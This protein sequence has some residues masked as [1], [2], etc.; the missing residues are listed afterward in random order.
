MSEKYRIAGSLIA[1]KR[2][3]VQ[4]IP[5]LTHCQLYAI[6]SLTP[7]AFLSLFLLFPLFFFR[8]PV[9][10]LSCL[11]V[12]YVPLSIAV[13][14]KQF[15][16]FS[17][18]LSQTFSLL[19]FLILYLPLDSRSRSPYLRSFSLSERAICPPAFSSSAF[20]PPLYTSTQRD[21]LIRC[22]PPS[23]HPFSNSLLLRCF[24][25]ADYSCASSLL[26]SL[27][28][29]LYQVPSSA[30]Q[31]LLIIIARQTNNVQVKIAGNVGNANWKFW[32]GNGIDISKDGKYRNE[33]RMFFICNAN[34]CSTVEESSEQE[35][36]C[37][38][39]L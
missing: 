3:F 12:H 8:S 27:S 23:L 4:P 21:S 14:K 11:I 19:L 38:P 24:R 9:L 6:L 13:S 22:S 17:F 25:S 18:F 33:R 7:S 16:L 20:I 5:R 31:Y 29:K 36:N 15:C 26:L 10:A 37:A 35:K 39:S 34:S 1:F 2:S 32:N 28:S 30:N